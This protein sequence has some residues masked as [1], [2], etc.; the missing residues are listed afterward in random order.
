MIDSIPMNKLLTLIFAINLIFPSCILA[1]NSEYSYQ[2][3]KIFSEILSPFCPGRSL[4]DCPSLSAS[5]LKTDIQKKIDKGIS[6]EKIMEDLFQ[7]YGSQIS[8]MPKLSGF[9]SLAWIV[10]ALFLILG[11]IVVFIITNSKKVPEEDTQ[12]DSS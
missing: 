8:A 11:G 9:G 12:Q 6:E 10:P 7:T 5:N 1:Q 2:A 3:E 4:K